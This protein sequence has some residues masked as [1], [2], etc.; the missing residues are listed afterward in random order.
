MDAADWPVVE[1]IYSAGMATG[2]ATFET[3]PPTWE[4]WDTGH[5]P[6]PRVVACNASGAIIGWAA[7]SP[8]SGRHAYRGVAEV[9]V[10][11]GPLT[12]RRGVGSA[13]LAA[14]IE[15]A[16]SVG[17]WTLQ[18]SI[19]RENSASL[20][21]H[22]RHGFR[23][24]GYRERIAQREGQWRDTLLLERRSPAPDGPGTAGPQTLEVSPRPR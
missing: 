22:Q 14:L 1:A 10:Y 16:A 17:L 8:V 18:A 2:N 7:L 3:E 12:W 13:L 15:G 23:L 5:L 9:S 20:R 4:Q 19:F 11:V 24:V 6:R 21:L